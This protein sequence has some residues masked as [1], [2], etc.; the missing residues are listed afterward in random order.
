MSFT[1]IEQL[2]INVM[3]AYGQKRLALHGKDATK[4]TAFYAVMEDRLNVKMV[5]TVEMMEEVARQLG[6]KYVTKGNSAKIVY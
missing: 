5:L 2:A 6:G 1:Q 4:R 3:V